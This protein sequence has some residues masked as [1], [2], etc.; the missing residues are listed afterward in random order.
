MLYIRVHL[1]D[2]RIMSVYHPVLDQI[3]PDSKQ[4]YPAVPHIARILPRKLRIVVY[5]AYQAQQRANRREYR[6]CQNQ[7]STLRRHK[8]PGSS[9]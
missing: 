4:H 2:I 9:A 3:D 5:L 7:R 8:P 6:P 1:R